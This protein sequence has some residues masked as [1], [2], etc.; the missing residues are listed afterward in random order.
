[1]NKYP[2][3]PAFEGEKYVSL[4]YKYEKADKDYTMI[5]L[6]EPV[7]VVEYMTDGSSVN[8]YRQYVKN[9]RGF[10]FVRKESMRD[11]DDL[12]DVFRN[13]IHY[14]S[15]SI[16]LKNKKFIAESPKKLMTVAAIPFG[17]ALYILIRY[18]TRTNQTMKIKK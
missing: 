7:C 12:K 2:P 10:A 3:Y 9:P 5:I 8:M 4:A 17:V 14:V 11:N 16:M 15:S 18:K 6:N 13:C 1:M